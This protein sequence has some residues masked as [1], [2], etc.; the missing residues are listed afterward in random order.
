MGSFFKYSFLY[1]FF[2]FHL[3]TT[4][5]RIRIGNFLDSTAWW[6]SFKECAPYNLFTILIFSS[7]FIE[8]MSFVVSTF[9]TSIPNSPCSLLHAT[10]VMGIISKGFF[11]SNVFQLQFLRIAS[12]GNYFLYSSWLIFSQKFLGIKVTSLPLSTCM[13]KNMPFN[14]IFL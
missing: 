6:L 12:R 8:L 11:V 10:P 14:F 9:N 5:I 7:A 4:I 13:W 3:A 1:H 2:F